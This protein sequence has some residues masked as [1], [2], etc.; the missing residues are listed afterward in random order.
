MARD[1]QQ[2]YP[3]PLPYPLLPRLSLFGLSTT[4]VPMK[5]ILITLLALMLCGCDNHVDVPE[6]P[7]IQYT[8]P[9][10][11]PGSY[12]PEKRITTGTKASTMCQMTFDGGKWNPD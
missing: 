12:R 5:I 9:I 7:A 2:T 10:I 11:T 8:T 6:E 1:A 3:Q 4:T